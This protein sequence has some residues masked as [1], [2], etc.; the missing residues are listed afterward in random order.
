MLNFDIHNY[1]SRNNNNFTALKC[2]MKKSEMS[3]YF[4]ST[5]VWNKLPADICST[6]DSLNLFM[7]KLRNYYLSLY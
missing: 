3:T 2:N 4:K 5:K 6:S 7:N 1:N